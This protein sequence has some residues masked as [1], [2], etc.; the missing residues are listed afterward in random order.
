[1]NPYS[2]T[3][4]PLDEIGDVGVALV[5]GQVE[6]VAQSP[7]IGAIVVDVVPASIGRGSEL[8]HVE[9]P[10]SDFHP[11]D[12]GYQLMVEALMEAYGL[13]DLGETEL[14]GFEDPIKLWE[15]RWQED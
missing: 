12:A 8:S 4:R 2:G 10:D 9:D 3:G 5:N 15:L 6:A 7:A 11:N 1:M 13:A 14:R